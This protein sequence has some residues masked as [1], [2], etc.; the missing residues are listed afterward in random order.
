MV[1]FASLVSTGF[2]RRR[3]PPFGG[4][5]L[6]DVFGHTHTNAAQERHT[7]PVAT[8][9]SRACLN[10]PRL[11]LELTAANSIS[12]QSLIAPWF[13]LGGNFPKVLNLK[14]TG[15][16]G[17]PY[18]VAG[19]WPRLFGSVL[20]EGTLDSLT[21][22][23][24]SPGHCCDPDQRPPTTALPNAHFQPLKGFVLGSARDFVCAHA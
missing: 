4:A 18:E 9:N 6:R 16:K 3:K 24:K 10:L 21:K 11:S 8:Q 23:A 12:R 2:K 1:P 22:T 15:F 13:Y 7:P 14:L 19:R 20:F 17:S 5:P